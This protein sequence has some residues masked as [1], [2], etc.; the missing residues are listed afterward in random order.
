MVVPGINGLLLACLVEALC[1][2]DPLRAYPDVA[3][4]FNGRA[5]PELR[6][7]IRLTDMDVRDEGSF[8]EK[9]KKRNSPS[10][11]T[12]GDRPILELLSS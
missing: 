11:K 1:L 4:D 9:K 8:R 12:V 3:S 5:E 6:L 10:R 2:L 7:T